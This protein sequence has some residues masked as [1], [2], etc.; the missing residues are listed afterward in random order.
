VSEAADLLE[1]Q[2]VDVEIIR[3]TKRL[4][5]LPEKR[6]ILE[7]RAK[8]RE[9][10]ALAAKA[11]T[12]VRKLESEVKVRQDEA[13]MLKE[14]ISSEQAKIMA[15]TDHRAVQSMTR[16]M[17]GLRRRNDKIEMEELQYM[18]RADKAKGQTAA[19]TD[20]LTKLAEK[21]A[22]LVERFKEVGGEVQTDIASLH[23][24]RERL[25]QGLPTELVERYEAIRASK[26]GVGVGRLEDTRC[27]ACRMELPAEKVQGLLSGP[28]VSVCPQCRRLIVV[29]DG[30][31]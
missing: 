24:R 7:A 20:H 16:E 26:S 6:A 4:Q 11:D 17:D 14:K 30:E 9:T 21:E 10:R 18:E 12:L 22:E 27:S 2:S 29:R 5:E 19:I 28:D 1:L 15:T 8:L 13:T 23:S 25:V 3:A 31:R